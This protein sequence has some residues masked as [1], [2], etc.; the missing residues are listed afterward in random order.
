MSGFLAA[1]L[2]LKIQVRLQSRIEFV[3]GGAHYRCVEVGGGAWRL[4]VRQFPELI[5]QRQIAGDL[6]LAQRQRRQPRPLD[7]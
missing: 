7:G 2:H 4:A 1:G 6:V 3:E 5:V